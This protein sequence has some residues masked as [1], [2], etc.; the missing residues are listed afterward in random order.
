MVKT[1]N[2]DKLT[3]D[4]LCGKK[5]AVEKGTVQEDPDIPTRSKACVTAGKPK[6]TTLSLSRRE[7][8]QPG[9]LQRPG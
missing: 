8:R 6:I 5:V 2:P 4:T 1:G 9:A 3:P 7:R